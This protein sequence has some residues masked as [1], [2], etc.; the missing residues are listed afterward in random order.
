MTDSHRI[1][2]ECPS[3]AADIVIDRAAA[4]ETI[5]GPGGFVLKCSHCTHVFHFHLEADVSG[6]RA[7]GG[8]ELLE[9]Y[10]D[11]Q[12]NKADVLKRHGLA[13]EA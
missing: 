7:A 5:G 11:R 1:I 2:I 8:A 3:C 4:A 6:A 9:V 10:H 12:G 13:A